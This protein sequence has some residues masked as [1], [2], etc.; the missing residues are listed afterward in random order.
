MSV[1]QNEV[2]LLQELLP[3]YY[4]HVERYP[5]TLLIKFYGLH[6]VVPL[7][8]SKVGRRDKGLNRP[9]NRSRLRQ[10]LCMLTESSESRP[11][12]NGCLDV[13]SKDQ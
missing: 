11:C 10:T 13:F 2:K 6:R 1:L 8:G 3:K 5:H 12:Q 7:N 9:D 4:A